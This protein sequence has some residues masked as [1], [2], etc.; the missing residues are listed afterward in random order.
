MTVI[1]GGVLVQQKLAYAGDLTIYF[2]FQKAA[3]PTATCAVHFKLAG[4]VSTR[5]VHHL[6][7]SA[8]SH[9][10]SSGTGSHE[11][12]ATFTPVDGID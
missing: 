6:G 9:T 11:A 3:M 4:T 2:G 7:V 1:L 10:T 5:F 12:V 8:V